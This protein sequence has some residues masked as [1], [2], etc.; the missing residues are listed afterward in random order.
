MA[1]CSF[2]KST[3]PGIDF[4]ATAGQDST[5]KI[6]GTV[7][8]A[9]FEHVIYNGK[10]ILTSV[11]SQFSITPV[12]GQ[13]TLVVVCLFTNQVGGVANLSED[14]VGGPVLDTLKIAD[15]DHGT[16]TYVISA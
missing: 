7:G 2:K 11:A 9:Y 1:A 5:I 16:R 6:A 10:D 4:D 15:P 8:D 13:K 3:T 12:K 14:C